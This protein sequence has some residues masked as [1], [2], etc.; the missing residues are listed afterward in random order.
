MIYDHSILISCRSHRQCFDTFGISFSDKRGGALACIYY[1]S[2][3][4][5]KMGVYH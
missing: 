2:D 3:L 1:A 4:K 5:V